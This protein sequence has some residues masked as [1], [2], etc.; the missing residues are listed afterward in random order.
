MWFRDSA[1]ASFLGPLLRWFIMFSKQPGAATARMPASSGAAGM[2]T[3]SF[4]TGLLRGD[5]RVANRSSN[6][7]LGL[8][9]QSSW[10]TVLG[11]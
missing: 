10:R 6:C 3:C 4:L 1:S 11:W 8:V 7:L 5:S 2:G 9:G